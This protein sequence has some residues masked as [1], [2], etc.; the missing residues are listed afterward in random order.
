MK[1]S[2]RLL[3]VASFVDD[4][5]NLIDV[6]CDHG[7]LDIYLAM[8][9][10][11]ISIIASDN[12]K[13]PYDRAKSN[14]LASGLDIKVQL[15]DGLDNIDKFTDTVLIA[16]MGGDGIND[17]L[18]KGRG[19]LGNI[20]TIILS[21][22]NKFYEVRCLLMKLGYYIDMESLV[23]DKEKI[24]LILKAKKGYRKYS[25]KE[26]LFGPVLLKEKSLLF[27]EYY[28]IYLEKGYE[29][30]ENIPKKYFWL[31]FNKKRNIRCIKKVLY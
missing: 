20:H 3:E 8:N 29:A 7:L 14:I 24:Y 30:L 2:K 12:K 26:L 10:K 17:I 18:I 31:R 25:Y 4:G 23:K 15:S 5:A 27:K 28:S 16:G 1:L 9:R 13:G 6:G 22:H 11:D 19:K 21:P